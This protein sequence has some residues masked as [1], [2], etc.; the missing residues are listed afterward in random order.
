MPRPLLRFNHPSARGLDED[1]DVELGEPRYHG[2]R[3]GVERN[4]SR[5]R[6]H[7]RER[8]PKMLDSAAMVG[9]FVGTFMFLWLSFTGGQHTRHHVCTISI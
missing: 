1:D 2:S 3:D 8:N 5:H 6:Y 4:R 7:Q 9:E